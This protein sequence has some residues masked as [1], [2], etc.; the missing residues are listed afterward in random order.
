[1]G[2]ALKTSVG[3]AL[4]EMYNACVVVVVSINSETDTSGSFFQ[5]F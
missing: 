4:A 5:F 1:M 2:V 3:T